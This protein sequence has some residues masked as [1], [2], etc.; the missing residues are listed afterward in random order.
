LALGFLPLAIVDEPDRG[1]AGIFRLAADGSERFHF[2]H[3]EGA[4]DVEVELGIAAAFIADRFG[5][6]GVESVVSDFHRA[7]MKG[8]LLAP[9]KASHWPQGARRSSPEHRPGN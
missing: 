2:A 8:G 1:A 6:Y 5:M 9:G 3:G 7:C 4:A